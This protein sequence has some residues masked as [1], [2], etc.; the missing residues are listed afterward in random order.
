MR[1]LLIGVALLGAVVAS[2]QAAKGSDPNKALDAKELAMLK[3]LEAKQV[4]AKAKF[5]K[6]PKDAA[7]KKAYIGS[8]IKLADAV[9]VS[10]AL[11]PRAKYPKALKHYREVRKVDPKN[12]HAKQQIDLIEGIYKSMGRPIP[13]G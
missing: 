6:A 4:A 3:S 2:S 5:V 7:M 10:P 11:A 1:V 8:T 13:P 9:L 12:A